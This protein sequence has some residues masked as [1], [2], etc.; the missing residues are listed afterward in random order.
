MN[1]VITGANRGIGLG[2]VQHYLSHGHDVW[3]CC[4]HDHASLDAIDSP[5][6]HR[7]HLDVCEDFDADDKMFPEVVDLL[8]NNAGVYGPGKG[9]QSLDAITADAMLEVFDVDC[10]GPIRVV[11]A[12]KSR[13]IK[14]QGV[15]ANMS[16]KM[17]SSADNASG[18]AYA[19]RAAKAALVMVSKSMAV[20]LSGMGVKVI[21]LHPGYVITDMTGQ[22]GLIDVAT[23]VAGLAN[24]INNID[25]YAAGSFIAYD[26]Q[27][28]PY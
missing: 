12:L 2:F 1:V 22:T 26:G 14:A 23:S 17:G 24:V 21:S 19:Y 5:H 18:G 4:R 28:V 25:Q 6:L 3:A 9:G 8:I 7:V 11:Q 16:S 27:I 10:V 20:D 15:I 13:L